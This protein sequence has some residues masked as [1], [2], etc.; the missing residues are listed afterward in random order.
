M[1]AIRQIGTAAARIAVDRNAFDRLKTLVKSGVCSVR[2][3]VHPDQTVQ[4]IDPYKPLITH[5][6]DTTRD[7]VTDV[8]DKQIYSSTLKPCQE[9]GQ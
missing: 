5:K 4:A 2:E 8:D 6:S 7:P 1:T 9:P 3:P